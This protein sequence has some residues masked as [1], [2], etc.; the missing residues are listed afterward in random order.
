MQ[1]FTTKNGQNQLKPVNFTSLV[2]YKIKRNLL[3]CNND[4]IKLCDKLGK[5]EIVV[6]RLTHD[7]S[8]TVICL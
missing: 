6:R 5:E 1:S 7:V 8:S 4:H 2:L 3:D